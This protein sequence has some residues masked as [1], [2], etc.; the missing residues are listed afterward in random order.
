ME[1][2]NP[3][4][5]VSQSGKQKRKGMMFIDYLRNGRGATGEKLKLT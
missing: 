4:K 1:E 5:Y 3:K 2:G